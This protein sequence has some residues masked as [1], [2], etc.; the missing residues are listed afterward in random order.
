[1]ARNLNH[2][3]VVDSEYKVYYSKVDRTK[4]LDKV[5][6]TGQVM[7][8][9]RAGTLPHFTVLHYTQELSIAVLSA[10]SEITVFEM[11]EPGRSSLSQKTCHL[12]L[13]LEL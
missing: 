4:P 12:E 1:M 5:K 9:V 13:Q 11:R 10:G 8:S 7:A 3:L 6:I 2:I